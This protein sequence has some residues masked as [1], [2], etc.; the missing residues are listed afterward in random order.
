MEEGSHEL[1]AEEHEGERL[2]SGE[3]G[4]RR[5]STSSCGRRESGSSIGRRESGSSIGRR[6]SGCS[7]GRRES[8]SSIGRRE[9]GSSSG[10]RE[11]GNSSDRRESGSSCGRWEGGCGE[12]GISLCPHSYCASDEF[13]DNNSK[14]DDTE[15]AAVRDTLHIFDAQANVDLSESLKE[16]SFEDDRLDDEVERRGSGASAFSLNDRRNSEDD[17]K[18][19]MIKQNVKDNRKEGLQ[20]SGELIEEEFVPSV[21]D[22]NRHSSTGADIPFVET[23]NEL[24]LHIPLLHSSN[25]DTKN[26]YLAVIAKVLHRLIS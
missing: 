9:S 24:L 2:E 12:R 16:E 17:R 1:Q 11:S 5:E 21:E 4:E 20:S 8:G 7:I 18:D 10:R 3:E 15:S 14:R 23:L 22:K 25:T 26:V 13:F 19:K 6:E